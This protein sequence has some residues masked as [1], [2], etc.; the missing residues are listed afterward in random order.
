MSGKSGGYVG[1][2]TVGAIALL[3]P[4]V[5]AR[6]LALIGRTMVT[7]SSTSS[8]IHVDVLP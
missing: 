4:D 3:P 8:Y 1:R 2:W 5:I 7:V 6:C